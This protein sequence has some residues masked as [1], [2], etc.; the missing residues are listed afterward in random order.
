MAR[1]LVLG[2]IG[3]GDW[4]AGPLRAQAGGR[5]QTTSKVELERWNEAIARA[6]KSTSGR[7]DTPEESGDDMRI[8]L[9]AGSD[10]ESEALISGGHGDL[11]SPD[12]PS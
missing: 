9:S 10:G 4:K 1:G 8:R 2:G 5:V 6:K 3:V 12:C 7:A 11:E